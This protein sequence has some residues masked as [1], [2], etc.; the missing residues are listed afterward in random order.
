MIV[1]PSFTCRL[2]DSIEAEVNVELRSVVTGSASEA[3]IYQNLI[4]LP[5]DV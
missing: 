3:S 5:A 4:K 1:I 2:I